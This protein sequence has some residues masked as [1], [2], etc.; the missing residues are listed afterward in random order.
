[1]TFKQ[2]RAA[3]LDCMV[4]EGELIKKY[5]DVYEDMGGHLSHAS[6]LDYAIDAFYKSKT[7]EQWNAI[8]I[9]MGEL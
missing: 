1:M 6:N 3:I 7:K 9:E 8:F 4:D 2:R 5:N